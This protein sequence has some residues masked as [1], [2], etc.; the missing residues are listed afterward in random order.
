MRKLLLGTIA[1]ASLFQGSACKA[2]DGPTVWLIMRSSV[3]QGGNAIE[4]VPFSSVEACETAALKLDAID[5]F[6]GRNRFFYTAC[7]ET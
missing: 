4:K 1:A 7:L 6:G 5:G 3:S 2:H